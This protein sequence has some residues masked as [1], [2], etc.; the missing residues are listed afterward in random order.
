MVWLVTVTIVT[1]PF[2]PLNV[3]FSMTHRL[4]LRQLAYA[5]TALG[6]LSFA[7]DISLYV[8][9]GT[10][11]AGSLL[12]GVYTGFLILVGYTLLGLFLQP[13]APHKV[14]EMIWV[15]SK[16]RVLSV[17]VVVFFSIY[18]VILAGFVLVDVDVFNILIGCYW[19]LV[20]AIGAML[21]ISI[22]VFSSRLANAIASNNEEHAKTSFDS[23]RKKLLRFKYGGYFVAMNMILTTP[24]MP[25]VFFTLGSFPFHWLIGALSDINAK[26]I[27]WAVSYLLFVRKSS[28]ASSSSKKVGNPSEL[29]F[30]SGKDILASS[31]LEN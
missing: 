10:F 18:G 13:I 2:I 12:V 17:C 14:Q 25:I 28:G 20:G 8:E 15:Q 19:L 27:F 4:R 16:M 31:T 9:R 26:G 6:I 1:V 23:L 11:G 7:K 29:Q 5:N 22:S 21:G 3:Y 30:G 24:I